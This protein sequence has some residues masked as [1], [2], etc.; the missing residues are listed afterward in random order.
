MFNNKEIRWMYPEA[1][2]G[3]IAKSVELEDGT[4]VVETDLFP[5]HR[6]FRASDGE[7]DDFETLAFSYNYKAKRF[8]V[9]DVTDD[10]LVQQWTQEASRTPMLTVDEPLRLTRRILKRWKIEHL[11]AEWQTA[12]A[13]EKR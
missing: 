2:G 9:T 10:P 7:G 11:A 8:D 4:A 1:S 13:G 12:P 3:G 6:R 5:P